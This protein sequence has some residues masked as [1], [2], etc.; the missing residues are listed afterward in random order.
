M[1]FL[2]NFLAE[3]ML[4]LSFVSIFAMTRL[5]KSLKFYGLIILLLVLMSPLYLLQNKNIIPM[6]IE[7]PSII[8]LIGFA[9][10]ILFRVAKVIGLKHSIKVNIQILSS[11]ISLEQMFSNLEKVLTIV[12][13]FGISTVVAEILIFPQKIAIPIIT[14]FA[15]FIVIVLTK[16]YMNNSKDPVSQTKNIIS[17]FL[18]LIT[19]FSLLIYI[20]G[21]LYF[22]QYIQQNLVLAAVTAAFFTIIPVSLADNYVLIK[23]GN[24]ILNEKSTNLSKVF[25]NSFS[26]YIYVIILLD[27]IT[28]DAP[29]VY[30][31]F[32]TAN[33]NSLFQWTIGFVIFLY[34]MLII[35][36]TK[37]AQFEL[38]SGIK[39]T[40]GINKEILKTQFL[41]AVHVAQKKRFKLNHN[42]FDAK[43]Y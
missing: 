25:I 16:F 13:I 14:L 1:S 9:L 41:S 23:F 33:L 39:N 34:S 36:V 6:Y 8:I 24:V 7:L 19:A 21:F 18:V 26:K 43:F 31:L 3:I 28:S 5:D 35:N 10:Y 27:I 20:L 22:Y 17:T 30:T 40:D 29:V 12:L 32:L 11:K 2:I 42:K 4:A 38:A 15:V 37:I